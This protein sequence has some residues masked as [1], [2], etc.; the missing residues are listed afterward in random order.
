MAGHKDHEGRI[1]K[2][3]ARPDPTLGNC[4]GKSAFVGTGVVGGLGLKTNRI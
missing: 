2:D 4:V 1:L 3:M